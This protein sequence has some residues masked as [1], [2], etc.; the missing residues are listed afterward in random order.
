[1]RS[2]IILI[3][4][5]FSHKNLVS[6]NTSYSE[7][8]NQSGE[9]CSYFGSNNMS[10]NENAE[11]LLEDIVSVIG[12]N[13][14]FFVLDCNNV[15]NARASAYKGKRYIHY[16]PS[17]M[18]DLLN[19]EKSVYNIAVFA[20]EIGHHVQGHSMDIVMQRLQGGTFL[21]P[22]TKEKSRRQEIE[23]DEF[24]GFVMQRLGY[25]L[26]EASSPIDSLA[27]KE[28]QTVMIIMILIPV[29]LRGMLPSR[30]DTKE[31]NLSQMLLEKV[32]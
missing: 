19:K 21:D 26:E 11:T 8:L 5:V 20:H 9:L 16:N 32:P 14:N 13:K 18:D 7:E 28:K 27:K 10:A 2:I 12:I 6:Q 31:E 15:P 29:L 23:A 4:F 24:S 30:G 3:V 25:S 17:F 22:L 1:M